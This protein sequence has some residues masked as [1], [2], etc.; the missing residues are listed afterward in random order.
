MRKTIQA[1]LDANGIEARTDHVPFTPTKNHP[2]GTRFKTTLTYEGR[3]ARLITYGGKIPDK[4]EYTPTIQLWHIHDD[5]DGYEATFERFLE[6]NGDYLHW[7]GRTGAKSMWKERKRY[8]EALQYV[9]GE[10]LFWQFYHL[11][12]S[13]D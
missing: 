4:E 11:P 6:E 2:A 13:A 7:L 1:F 5:I 9:L 10:T 3:K 12:N 8:W